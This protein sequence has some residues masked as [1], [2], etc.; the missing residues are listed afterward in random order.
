MNDLP[1]HTLASL[2]RVLVA[3][4]VSLALAVPAGVFAGSR[5][6][7]DR[8]VSPLAY[9]L[10]PIPKIAFLPAFIVLL[11]LGEASKLALLVT[12]LIFPLYLAAR[13]GVRDIPSELVI[14]A[15]TLGL[16]GWSLTSHVYLPALLPRLFSALRLGVGIA[17]SVLFFAENF[18][19]EFGLGSLVMNQW[20][21]MRYADMSWGIAALSLLGLV[22]FAAVDLLERWACPWSARRRE[23]A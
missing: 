21:I 9:L 11:G 6:R 1:L 2:A 7:V 22:M 17:L 14:S 5:P 23:E 19:T 8:W 15:R 16:R 13:D 10:Y 4:V 3:L 18:S 20:A 12:I